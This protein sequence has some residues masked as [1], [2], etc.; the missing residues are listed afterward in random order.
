VL[1]FQPEWETDKTYLEMTGDSDIFMSFRSSV[2]V[3]LFEVRANDR[4]ESI[5]P[6]VAWGAGR[7]HRIADAWNDGAGVPV[8]S[9]PH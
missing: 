6:P 5:E 8:H 2:I 9:A 7:N 1:W 3:A 4:L